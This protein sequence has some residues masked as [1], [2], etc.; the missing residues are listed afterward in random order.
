MFE[1]IKTK[2]A[3]SARK[4]VTAGVAATMFA[5][6]LFGAGQTAQAQSVREEIQ[7][8]Y[9]ISHVAERIA[10]FQEK[11]MGIQSYASTD[12]IINGL[13]KQPGVTENRPM[14]DQ[15][16]VNA[17]PA[18]TTPSPTNEEKTP[19]PI[20]STKPVD[21]ATPTPTTPSEQPSVSTPTDEKTP[22]PAETTPAPIPAP[23]DDATPA[24]VEPT[25]PPVPSDEE[26]PN[27]TKP[28]V[29]PVEEDVPA[30]VEPAAPVTPSNETKPVEETTPVAPETP[31]EPSTP[32]PTPTIPSDEETPNITKPTVPPT[33]D[34]TTPA[35][36]TTPTTPTTPSDEENTPAKPVVRHVTYT[37]DAGKT[38]TTEI[39]GDSLPETVTIDGVEMVVADRS[40]GSEGDIIRQVTVRYESRSY[41][42]DWR[43]EIRVDG[44]VINTVNTHVTYNVRYDN[45]T[46]TEG[47]H[48]T[49][50]RLFESVLEKIRH[51]YDISPNATITHDGQSI[52]IAWST[53]I[54]TP[55][56]TPQPPVDTTPPSDHID[57]KPP[58]ENHSTEKPSVEKVTDV[59]KMKSII[60][61]YS[62][63]LPTLNSN[64][65]TGDTVNDLMAQPNGV[66]VVNARLNAQFVNRANELRAKLGLS[67]VSIDESFNA[68][69]SDDLKSHLVASYN[70]RDHVESSGRDAMFDEAD[71]MMESMVP[72]ST[73]RTLHDVTPE[74]LADY[75]F[76]MFIGEWK[77]LGSNDDS[78]G[79]LQQVIQDLDGLKW[80]GGVHI[81]SMTHEAGRGILANVDMSVYNL[82]IVMIEYK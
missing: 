12:D 3:S 69:H 42:Q 60:K 1:A 19:A 33:D 30:P 34:S 67:P 64:T 24:P 5:G 2:S 74:A 22:A 18:E 37:D 13:F 23:T 21:E 71:I 55:A 54:K 52:Q 36:P 76:K 61:E 80:I 9:S 26:T 41:A 40:V 73:I 65:Y 11:V 32:T 79:H 70:A 7:S 68:R 57:E 49:E 10:G 25:V 58:V 72:T 27:I 39:N 66:D 8:K 16:G 81:G 50:Q 17:P 20:E 35:E 82:S 44:R 14:V 48:P 63:T 38:L 77:V 29:P 59:T 53:L 47:A 46:Q 4:I 78:D 62:E 28:T 45:L 43:T 51:D 56:E 75:A 15:P 6:A 31:S